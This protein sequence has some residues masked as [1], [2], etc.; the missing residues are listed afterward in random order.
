[1][2]LTI[3]P[4]Q[5]APNIAQAVL[6]PVETGELGATLTHEHLN[7]LVPDNSLAG[8]REVDRAEVAIQALTPA[9]DFGIHTALVMG[10]SAC[11]GRL[12]N[13]F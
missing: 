12:H 2:E 13:T 11:R 3:G 1:M 5:R 4:A 10:T 8:G 6:G 9:P 7:C